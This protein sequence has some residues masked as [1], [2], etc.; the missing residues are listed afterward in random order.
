MPFII[1]GSTSSDSSSCSPTWGVTD[2]LKESGMG[3]SSLVCEGNMDEDN[4][5]FD[6]EGPKE[7]SSEVDGRGGG[8]NPFDGYTVS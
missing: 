4:E 6:T 8:S 5:S 2:A 7:P 3:D 1:N